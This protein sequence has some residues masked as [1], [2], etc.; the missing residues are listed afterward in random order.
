MSELRVQRFSDPAFLTRVGEGE[1]V[2]AFGWAIR[3]DGDVFFDGEQVGHSGKFMFNRDRVTP[4]AE[5]TY[6][7]L[8]P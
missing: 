5:I 8:D 7:E 2:P 6:E 3:L 4:Y 1:Q